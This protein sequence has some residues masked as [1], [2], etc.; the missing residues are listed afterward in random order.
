MYGNGEVTGTNKGKE[1]TQLVWLY[2]QWIERGEHYPENY[3]TSLRS[4]SI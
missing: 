3:A 2:H 4:C 1:L